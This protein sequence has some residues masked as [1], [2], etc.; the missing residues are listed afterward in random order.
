MNENYSQKTTKNITNMIS[1]PKDFSKDK[2]PLDTLIKEG[3]FNS[4]EQPSYHH[5][6]L[7]YLRKADF[8]KI[9]ADNPDIKAITIAGVRVMRLKD[10]IVTLVE[11]PDLKQNE[12]F[13]ATPAIVRWSK[14]R[15]A[16]AKHKQ[17]TGNAR[18]GE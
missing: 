7:R 15:D 4:T 18:R 5:E 14:E 17:C 16:N 13:I 3:M 9:M 10:S 2:Y 12:I 6:P 8:E 11:S 1:I